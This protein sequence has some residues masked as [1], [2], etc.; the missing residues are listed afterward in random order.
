M[1]YHTLFVRWRG[2]LSDSGAFGHMGGYRR[3]FAPGAVLAVSEHPPA[4][5]R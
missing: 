3:Q 4:D 2:T 1:G 5:C